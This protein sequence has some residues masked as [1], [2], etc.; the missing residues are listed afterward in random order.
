MSR[1]YKNTATVSFLLKDVKIFNIWHQIYLTLS[2]DILY[3]DKPGQRKDGLNECKNCWENLNSNPDVTKS[4]LEVRTCSGLVRTNI[5]QRKS[6]GHF[7]SSELLLF[8]SFWGQLLTIF[9]NTRLSDSR[10]QCYGG[11]YV[12][13]RKMLSSLWVSGISYCI[14]ALTRHRYIAQ[15]YTQ[16]VTELLQN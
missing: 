16:P 11:V 1:R 2:W 6:F 8:G 15:Y 5:E 9:W 12:T 4:T 10:T 3:I 14:R 13:V 7:L